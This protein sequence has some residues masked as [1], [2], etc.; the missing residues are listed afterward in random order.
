MEIAEWLAPMYRHYMVHDGYRRLEV[1]FFDNR[2]TSGAV[3]LA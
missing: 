3:L 1:H 2:D